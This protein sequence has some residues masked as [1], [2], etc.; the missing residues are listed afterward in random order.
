MLVFGGVYCILET[1]QKKSCRGVVFG[2]KK[3]LCSKNI[4]TKK[5]SCIAHCLDLVVPVPPAARAMTN[6]RHVTSI[7][8]C[9]R[10]KHLAV[11]TVA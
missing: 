8:S 6:A 11:A 9:T 3:H 2:G 10:Y 7:V 5:L 1:F 4:T